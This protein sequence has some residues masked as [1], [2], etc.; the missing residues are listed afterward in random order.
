MLMKVTALG[1]LLC[2]GQCFCQGV[3]VN[4][5]GLPEHGLMLNA[6]LNS[7]Q[8]G[9]ATYQFEFQNLNSKR[10]VAY[11]LAWT[12]IGPGGRPVTTY[13]NFYSTQEFL[14]GGVPH[15]VH[16]PPSSHSL[17]PGEKRVISPISN[18]PA[19]F[20][21]Q[22][23][24]PGKFLSS[25]ANDASVTLALDAVVFEDGTLVGPDN[26][27]LYS[28]VTQELKG[29]DDLLKAALATQDDNALLAMLKSTGTL[30]N[31]KILT[32]PANADPQKFYTYHKAEAARML[33]AMYKARG[34]AAARDMAGKVRYRQLP[35]LRKI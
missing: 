2:C 22:L 5:K 26:S 12:Y 9:I 18:K 32:N 19:G 30:S 6:P 35:T 20:S 8:G 14:D 1:V 33:E 11:A 21:G 10:V 16:D 4:T 23:P 29:Y 31:S 13:D 7:N 34:A 24:P 3:V 17:K 15:L 28:K 25:H 27:N